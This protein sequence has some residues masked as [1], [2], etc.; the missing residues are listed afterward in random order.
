MS[1]ATVDDVKGCFRNF[2]SNSEAAVT[3]AKIEAWLE[4]AHAM[5]NGRIGTLYSMPITEDD[6][7]ES[8]KILAQIEAFKVAG[9]VDDI[10]NSYSE[11]D[12]KPTWEKRA[13]DMLL[14]LVP[15]KDKD[16]KQPEPTTKLPDAIYIGTRQQTARPKFSSGNTDAPTFVK[17]GDNW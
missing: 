4:S 5:I 8:F 10:L 15:K 9:I 11:A 16:G 17:G 2:A 7:P 3:D 1:Y 14:E 12:K 6:Y 13:M